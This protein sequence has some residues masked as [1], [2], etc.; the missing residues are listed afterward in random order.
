MKPAVRYI[1]APSPGATRTSPA[2]DS[3]PDLELELRHAAEHGTVATIDRLLAGG[4]DVDAANCA[5]NTA[6]HYAAWCG[7]TAAI[8]AL[9]AA[10]AESARATA[11]APPLWTLPS[12]TADRT[13]H[14]ASQPE[15]PTAAK[16][17]TRH[18]ILSRSVV[19]APKSSNSTRAHLVQSRLPG[20]SNRFPSTQ[21]NRKHA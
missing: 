21:R 10:G 17:R 3:G 12:A 20:G 1:D 13:R 6:L 18:A 2:T 4:V 8:E 9:L 11:T 14:S 15:R 16:V 7:R 19:N 5:G